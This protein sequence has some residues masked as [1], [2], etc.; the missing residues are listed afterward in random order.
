VVNRLI[1]T[2]NRQTAS[3]DSRKVAFR[4]RAPW[5]TLLSRMS[6]GPSS[7]SARRR[8]PGWRPGRCSRRPGQ[9]PDAGAL[10]IGAQ[11]G[12]CV[13]FAVDDG[14]GG[15]S[16]TSRS[17]QPRPMPLAPP[18]TRA[19]LPSGGADSAQLGSMLTLATGRATRSLSR[20][21]PR[22]A[23]HFWGSGHDVRSSARSRRGTTPRADWRSVSPPPY[24]GRAIAQRSW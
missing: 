1:S 16:R 10:Q 7:A 22:A 3:S 21:R 18:V 9:E 20:R 6:G 24:N 8:R 17:T 15:P 2:T 5:P 14:D 13:R 19:T 12:Q 23:S 4:S 11:L